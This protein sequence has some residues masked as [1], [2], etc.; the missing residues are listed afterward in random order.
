MT[1]PAPGLRGSFML[2][3]TFHYFAAKGSTWAVTTNMSDDPVPVTEEVEA[4]ISTALAKQKKPRNGVA[5]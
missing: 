1:T 2:G 4:A 5:P 3:G